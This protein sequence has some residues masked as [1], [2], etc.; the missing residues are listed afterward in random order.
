MN[1]PNKLTLLRIILVPVIVA[2]YMVAPTKY[3][4]TVEVILDG[5]YDTSDATATGTID[6]PFKTITAA[7]ASYPPQTG[8]VLYLREGTYPIEDSVSLKSVVATEELP[9]IISSY[10][11]EEVI[12]SGGTNISGADFEKITILVHIR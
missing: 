7:L 5:Y 4:G 2:V 8:M 9:F 11:N 3:H 6:K 12:V 1:L 10:N